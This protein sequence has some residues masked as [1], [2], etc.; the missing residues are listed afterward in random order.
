[1]KGI[2]G[3]IFYSSR[4]LR[5]RRL[6]VGGILHVQDPLFQYTDSVNFLPFTFF[7]LTRQ[8]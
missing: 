6:R 1:M 2:S 4:L 3:V 5:D 7:L 8:F